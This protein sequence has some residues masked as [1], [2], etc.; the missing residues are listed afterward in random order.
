MRVSNG[1]FELIAFVLLNSHHLVGAVPA[2]AFHLLQARGGTP[3]P[4]DKKDG[5][6]AGQAKGK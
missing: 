3:P 1:A 6:P 2:P 4:D 5:L